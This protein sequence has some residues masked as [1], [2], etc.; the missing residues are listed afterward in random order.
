[1]RWVHV[2]LTI[3][4]LAGCE[5]RTEPP[6]KDQSVRPARIFQ[7]VAEGAATVYEFV[8]R[9]EAAQTVDVSFEVSGPLAQLPVREGQTVPA[10]SLIAALDPTDFLLAVREAEVQLRLAAADFKRK[11]QLLADRGI[12]RSVVDDARA[13]YELRQVH[14]TQAKEALADSKIYAP[15]SAYIA[16]RFTDNHVNVTPEDN[17]ARLTDLAELLIRTNMPESILATATEER[18]LSREARFSFAPD[19]RFP[20]EFREN[21]GEADAVAQTYQVTF[22]M[23]RPQEW[24]ILPG[25]SATVSLELAAEDQDLS[26]VRIPTTALIGDS[27]G[28]FFVWVFDAGSGGVEKRP[29]DVGPASGAGV[30]IRDGL[31]DGELIVAAGASGLRT[32]MHV[33]MLGELVTDI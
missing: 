28:G 18:V 11:R 21:T 1:V 10:G 3:A 29:V 22:A 25:M 16:R 32:G 20:L 7:V 9:V 27:A 26:G 19:Q 14:V 31:R 30:P 6:V 12:S 8:G 24:N 15:F 4:V 23:P 17:I 5:D 33:R 2:L 13:T